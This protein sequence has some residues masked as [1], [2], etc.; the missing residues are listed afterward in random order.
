MQ[1]NGNTAKHR[2]QSKGTRPGGREIVARKASHLRDNL[3]RLAHEVRMKSK[4][5]SAE[6]KSTR[7]ALEREV[8][9]FSEQVKS[10]AEEPYDDLQQQAEDLRMRFQKLA[11]QIVMPAI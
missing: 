6:V 11:N 1:Q 5:A 2:T 8:E 3:W 4:G 10:A 9:R 7:V